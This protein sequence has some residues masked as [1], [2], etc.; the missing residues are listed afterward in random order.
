M[1]AKLQSP[2]AIQR[3]SLED[4][5]PLSTPL[6]I[7]LEPSGYCNLKCEFCPHSFSGGGI[8]KDIMEFSLVR[9]LV[10]DIKEFDQKLAMV[11]ICGDGEPLLNPKITDIIKYLYESKIAN[12][13]EL[14]TN[15]ILMTNEISDEIAKYCNRIII[16]IEGL[17][18]DSYVKFTGRSIQ[19][20]KLRQQI[21]YLYRKRECI[22]HVKI[23]DKA[24]SNVENGRELFFKM[25]SQIC[26]EIDIENLI[27]MWPEFESS[28]DLKDRKEFRYS[29]NENK[30]KNNKVVCPQIFKSLQIYA[31]G[32]ITPCCVDWKRI[33]NLGNINEISI[34][35]IWKDQLEA[36]QI[37]HLRGE[38]FSFA[39]CKSCI[40]NDYC[41]VDDIDKNRYEI[42][43]KIRKGN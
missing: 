7:Y 6:I 36:L 43:Q 19:V 23:H 25:F 20:E 26:D 31:N 28:L 42:L 33:N 37:K 3:I 32:D 14:V 40:L 39:P 9:K 18:E 24:L 35:K 38:R 12:K 41:E 15:G 21:A 29:V 22:V 2:V 34:K 8:L 10:D 5:A 30:V 27:D 4:A 16:S 1:N 13:I 17:D 11:R